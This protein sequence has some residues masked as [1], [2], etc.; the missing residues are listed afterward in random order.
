MRVASSAMMG[1]GRERLSLW[2]LREYGAWRC[3]CVCVCLRLRLRGFVR[4]RLYVVGASLA[5][6]RRVFSVFG[7]WQRVHGA[8]VFVP[9]A[10]PSVRGCL[11][12][13]G[14]LHARDAGHAGVRA[15]TAG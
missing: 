4:L 1:L 7:I 2:R 15:A 10:V 11:L 9:S 14:R 13:Q 12:W 3:V 5:Y 8:V 6:L